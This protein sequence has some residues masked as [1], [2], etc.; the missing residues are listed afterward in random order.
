M[1]DAPTILAVVPARGG[2]KRVPRKNILPL[3]GRPLVAWTIEAALSS[4]VLAD[5]LVSTDDE[6]IADVSQRYGALVPWL[7]PAELS[8]DTATSASVL[9]HALAWYERERRVVDAV[10]LLQPTSPFRTVETIR[11]AASKYASLGSCPATLVSVSK[12]QQHP[13]WCFSLN[14][15]EMRPFLG[16][17]G[18]HSRSQDLPSA[19]ALNGC[20]YIIP[21]SDIRE[22]LPIIHPGICA[23]VMDSADEAL[24][25]DTVEDWLAAERHADRLGRSNR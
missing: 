13:Q 22:G 15:D 10:V 2:S 6:E 5:V 19:Y 18:I 3:G 7:R 1:A 17:D 14:G 16:W 9:G 20:I 23:F 8:T 25:I 24:D 21:A 4:G 11:A 12:V